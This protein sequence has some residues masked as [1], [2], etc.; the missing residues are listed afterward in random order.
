MEKRSAANSRI[1]GFQKE[2]LVSSDFLGIEESLII[3]E[4]WLHANE[5]RNLKLILWYDNEWGYSNRVA[6]MVNLMA[7]HLE[8]PAAASGAKRL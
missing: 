4:R 3:D 1:V 6:D 8:Q 2:S 7:R 5:D